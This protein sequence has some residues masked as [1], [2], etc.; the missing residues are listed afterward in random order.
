MTYGQFL[1]AASKEAYHG[2]VVMRESRRDSAMQENLMKAIQ[3]PEFYHEV[4]E[5]E[6]I[7]LI[8]GAKFIGKPHY[9]KKEQMMCAIDG[10]LDV[11]FVPHVYRQEV[12]AGQNI[13]QTPYYEFHEGTRVQTNE[14]ILQQ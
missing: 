3:L 11:V 1:E 5:L 8:Q 12:Y 2:S 9:E 13:E 14:V 10:S 6:D 7:E 4:S